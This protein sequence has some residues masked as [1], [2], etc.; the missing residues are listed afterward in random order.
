MK[1]STMREFGDFNVLKNEEI[2]TPKPKAGNILIKVLAAGVNRLDDYIREGSIVPELPFPHILGADA[3]GEVAEIGVGVTGFETGE[4]VILVPGYAQ[5]QEETDIR[6]TV[7]APSFALPGLHTSGTYTQYYEA[8]AY[9]VVKDETGLKPEEV[10][11]F[12][13]VLATS[14]HAVKGIGEV[15]AGDKV[16]VH[17]GSS[18]SGS[19]HIQVAKALGA[20]VATTI[21]KEGDREFVQNLGADLII[22]SKDEDFVAKVQEWTGGSGVDVV[23][24]NLAGDVLAKSIEAAKPLG[25]VV[26]FGFA[27]GPEVKFDIRSLFFAQKKLRG[28]MASDLEDL[29]L[30][31]ELVKQGKIKPLLDKTFPLS[32]A[33][34]AHRYIAS[35]QVKGNIV[36]LPWAA[37]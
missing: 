20:E 34:E 17:S 29:K 33:S 8:P 14:I 3:A 27:A 12:P 37:Y 25:V 1:A 18:G 5:N 6:P 31:L 16:L 35:N 2:E 21:R 15:K 9:A 28:S 23:I 22:N 30:G 11:T 4:R 26:A 36:L 32:Q 24:D 10:A 13:V 19:M 7:T